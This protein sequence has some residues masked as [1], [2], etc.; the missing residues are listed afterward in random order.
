MKQDRRDYLWI[1]ALVVFAMVLRFLTN[2][3]YGFHRDEFLYIS[4][5]QHLDW[6]YWSNPPGPGFFSWLTQ[7]MIG[8]SI[9]AIRFFP[10][11]VG[12][13]TILLVCM[14]A[15][16]MGG[17]RFAQMLAG[18]SIMFSNAMPR[19]FL[20]YNPVP[21]DVFYWTL[22]AFLLVKYLSS[23]QRKYILWLGVTI[24]LGVLNKYSI[25]FL[26]IPASVALIF[27]AHRH[28]LRSKELY[29]AAVITTLIILPNLLWQW[30]Y[31]FP[32][33]GHMSELRS[34]QLVN[35]RIIDFLKDQLLFNSSVLLIWLAGLWYL[36]FTKN[37]RRFRPVGITFGGIIL[38]LMVLKGKSYYTLGAYPM[39]LAA[40]ACLW[41]QWTIGNKWLRIIPI[42]VT[43]L[44]FRYTLPF[45]VPYLSLDRMVTFGKEMVDNG[46]D[47][48]VRWEDGQVH[49]LPQD[50]ADMLGWKEMADLVVEAVHTLD[51]PS[52]CLIYCQNFGQ[53]GAV[54]YY[55]GKQGIPMPVSFADAYLLWVPEQIDPSVQDFI[56]VNDEMGEDVQDLFRKITVIGQV[57]N[58][59]AREE[60][61]TVYLCQDP[62]ASLK[63]FWS[64]RVVEVKTAL[65]LPL[66][67]KP[68]TAN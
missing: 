4:Q 45:S 7:W 25:V 34:T 56:Y 61:T 17:G 35:V 24:G 64:S 18:L 26:I 11:L 9:F 51:D 12:G 5:G 30:K 8:D 40:G 41:E 32:V 31:D 58:P 55:G 48:M 47:G 66:N 23:E 54:A 3:N 16:E 14:M 6:G 63:D 49:E 46:L 28:L 53:A 44:V 59:Y 19:V 57:D 15:R 43:I 38:L 62:T 37:G 10:G 1:G 36:F 2:R 29:I 52:K 50:Y 60:G 22:F 67:E 65:G 68:L 20:M 39:L 13:L 21:F 33:I 42:I 27:S